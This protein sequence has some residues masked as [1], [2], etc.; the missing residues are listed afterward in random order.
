MADEQSSA[1]SKAP[2]FNYLLQLPIIILAL[3][4]AVAHA[5][6]GKDSAPVI[7]T[8]TLG[9]LLLVAAG[10]VLHR[11]KG[12]KLGEGE[13]TFAE[14]Q[15][16]QQVAQVLD[17]AYP[18]TTALLRTWMISLDSL[19]ESYEKLKDKDDAGA[20]FI[21]FVV[22]RMQEA[23][24]LIRAPE[25]YVRMSIWWYSEKEDRL[26]L[27]VASYEVDEQKKWSY[28]FAPRE[29]LIGQA[30]V[31]NAAVVTYGDAPSETFF[32]RVGK[33]PTFHGLLMVP[34]RY[35]HKPVGILSVDRKKKGKFANE[36]E[37]VAVALADL[38]AI[39]A[40]YPNFRQL[41]RLLPSRPA[42]E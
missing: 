11:I 16:V 8:I 2:K 15:A 23:I 13:L 14:E 39:A 27:L 25:D 1:P 36:V 30:F 20:I 26:K 7:D 17:I 6:A 3:T 31:D 42:S 18:K 41:V 12:L 9:L 40:T 38:V 33:D 28:G 22:E 21:R 10:L 34:I 32:K 37:D 35:H 29:G 5:Y 19:A 24:D 4:A